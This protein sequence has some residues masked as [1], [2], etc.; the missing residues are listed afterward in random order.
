MPKAFLIRKNLQQQ[1]QNH[2]HQ[3]QQQQQNPITNHNVIPSSKSGWSPV[4]PPPSPDDNE[5]ENLS[6][7]ANI[8]PAHQYNNS[9]QQSQQQQQPRYDHI[10]ALDLKNKNFHQKFID[11]N[12]NNDDEDMD[13]AVDLTCSSSLSSVSSSPP[14]LNSHHP[15]KRNRNISTSENSSCS[16]S[17][18]T[19][20]SHC[21]GSLSSPLS[22]HSSESD[23]DIKG[24]FI[25]R[26]FY[27]RN[28]K[29]IRNSVIQLL[30]MVYTQMTCYSLFSN[31]IV[32]LFDCYG[33]KFSIFLKKYN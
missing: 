31:S 27:N 9:H 10:G 19:T 29:N 16:Y 18:S 5:P 8:L 13:E 33:I 26:K 7:K 15:R 24:K 6:I 21:Y 12:N 1:Y 22:Y 28:K 25:I 4:T 3:Q 20:S 2:C 14:Q 11:N 30:C 17:S 32:K 23:F